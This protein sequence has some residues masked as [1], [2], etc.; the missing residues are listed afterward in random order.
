MTRLLIFNLGLLTTMTE[1]N[2]TI[3]YTEPKIFTVVPGNIK[4]EF[5]N[6]W[7]ETKTLQPIYQCNLSFTK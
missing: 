2:M 3:L 1:L 4:K 7:T 5:A 6:P